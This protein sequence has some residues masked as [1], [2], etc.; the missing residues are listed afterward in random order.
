MADDSQFP[1][2]PKN[3]LDE[4]KKRFP[5]KV[6]TNKSFTWEDF[7]FLQGQISVINLLEKHFEIQNKTVLESKP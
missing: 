6:P 4:L 5:N 2:I 1:P 3:L 7:R